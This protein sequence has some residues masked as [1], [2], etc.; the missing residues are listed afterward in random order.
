MAA[1]VETLVRELDLAPLDEVLPGYS[2][3]F[4]V[5]SDETALDLFVVNR[6]GEFFA[7]E[8]RCPHTGVNLNWQPDQFLDID[9]QFIQCAMHGALF[10]IDDG[11]CLRGP[12]VGQL[13]RAL[14]LRVRDGRLWLD[15]DTDTGT[16]SADA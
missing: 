13:L 10:R 14:P 1:A 9:H 11:V 12:C 6:N 16:T 7:F 15:V 5:G 8:N 2:R 3:G 4:R